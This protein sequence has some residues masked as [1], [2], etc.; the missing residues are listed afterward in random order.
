MI[1]KITSVF[2]MLF[3]AALLAAPVGALYLI[4]KQEIMLLEEKDI[5]EIQELSYGE[6]KKLFYGSIGE[7]ITVNGTVISR[8]QIFMD[9]PG[10]NLDKMRLIVNSGDYI[11]SGWVIGYLNKEEVIADKSGVIREINLSYPAYF[12][13]D[14]V[15]CCA[16]ECY[17]PAE[18]VRRLSVGDQLSDCGGTVYEV[19]QIDPVGN[20]NGVRALLEAKNGSLTYGV[21]MNE[22]SLQ[23]DRRIDG[24]LL[25]PKECVYSY[26][27]SDQKYIRVVDADGVFQRELEVKTLYSDDSFVSVSGDDIVEGLYCDSGYKAIVEGS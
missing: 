10:Y 5:L 26:P 8:E 18:T 11:A 2:L 22:L 1:R 20:A 12:L 25:A 7:S 9:I 14:S 16:L 13:L 15:E 4:S 6:P 17:I 23:P 27:N 3:F 21:S 24:V 19:L